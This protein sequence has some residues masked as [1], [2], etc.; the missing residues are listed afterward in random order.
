MKLPSVHQIIKD[1]S[2]TFLRFPFAL[3]SAAIGTMAALILV[4]YEGPPSATVLFNILL[5]SILGIPL[6]TAFALVAEKGKWGKSKSSITQLV[7][8][9]LLAA[10]AIS[11]PSDL[12]DA[13]II[14]VL[15]LLILS[16]ALHFFVAVAPFFRRG[17]IN[18]FWHYNK[19]L[20]LQLLTAVVYSIVL[21]AGLSL[22]LAALD[23]LFGINVPGKRYGE[24]AILITGLFNTWF[25]LSGVPEDLD[26]LDASTDYPKVLKVFAQYILFPLV[27]IYLVIL[28]AYL[29]KILIVWDWP[30]GWVSKLILGFSTTGILSLLLF[31]PIRDHV[32]NVW[33]KTASRWFYFLMIPIV[34][35]L[36]PALWRRISE[37]GITE[38]R[39]IAVALGVWLAA[40]VAYFILSKTKS[41]KVIP[42]SLC[43]LAFLVSFGPW[44]AFEVSEKSQVERLRDL[45]VRNSILVDGTIHKAQVSITFEDTKQ[46]SSI[47]SYLH[48]IHGYDRI[49]PWFRESLLQDSAGR[50]LAYKDPALVAK[51]L[52]IEYVHVWLS[53]DQDEI[54]LNADR[55][56]TII[57]EGYDRM[58]RAQ[59]IN[60][61]Q[62]KKDFTGEEIAYR[63]SAGLDTMIF[64]VMRDG[65]AVDSL[66]IGLREFIEKLLKDYG[67]ANAGNIPPEKMSISTTNQT[68]KLK[69]YL[70]QIHVRKQGSETKIIDYET[71][72]LYAINKSPLSN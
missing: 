14:H 49:Q 46:I 38:G 18:G 13:P 58:L 9:L 33:I 6:L 56:S 59:H 62:M 69:L 2:R 50:R 22:A 5:A 20:L 45:L 47:I 23:H 31:H 66:Q 7:G 35:M 24:L 27:L 11:V 34:I 67:N 68:M 28:Y 19:T 61:S 70:R 8:V 65:R 57:V 21:N 1:S 29:A 71:E 55:E 32:E 4:D 36:F 48:E 52:G 12:A 64:F 10:Y 17:E 30:Q 37:Y 63:V 39:Y 16:I 72:I 42:A 43:V 44:G 53:A 51:I 3:V 54:M 25:F 60:D 26:S 40:M 15:R 41:I